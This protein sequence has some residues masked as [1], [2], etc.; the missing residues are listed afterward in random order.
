MDKTL[1]FYPLLRIVL[2]FIVGIVIGEAFGERFPLWL[3]LVPAAAV[4]GVCLSASNKYEAV[5]RPMHYG[6]VCSSCASC[7]SVG[8]T[9]YW[10]LPC[11]GRHRNTKSVY[12]SLEI[13]WDMHV[14]FAILNRTNFFLTQIGH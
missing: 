13:Q 7:L 11:R 14:V 8:T 2:I 4:M 5:P 9:A 10:R 12:G 1:N 6:K 3:W